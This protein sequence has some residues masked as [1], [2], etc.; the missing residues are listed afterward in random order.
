M[1]APAL[2]PAL[3]ELVVRL[4]QLRPLIDA[5][6]RKNKEAHESEATAEADYGKVYNTAFLRHRVPDG[7]GKKP[8]EAEAKAASELE[9]ESVKVRLLAAVSMRRATQDALTAWVKELEVI[10]AIA[11]AYNRELR[12]LG[13]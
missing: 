8:T 7:N 12:V 9:A 11:N 4:D 2:S 3:Q 13:G 6:I 5:A 10:Q 1:T